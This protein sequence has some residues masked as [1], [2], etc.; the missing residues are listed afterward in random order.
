MCWNV[1]K[2]LHIENLL[3]N[4]AAVINL[5]YVGIDH[6]SYETRA[7]LNVIKTQKASSQNSHSV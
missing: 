2:L 5:I 7:T 3:V 1:K 4:L 6:V